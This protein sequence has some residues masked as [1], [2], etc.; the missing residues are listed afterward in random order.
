MALSM[1]VLKISNKNTE[2]HHFNHS[3]V[4]DTWP[5]T[6]ANICDQLSTF[7]NPTNLSSN[8][9]PAATYFLWIA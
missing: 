8:L 9:R 2:N 3:T 6:D 4:F 7:G 5:L 1:Y